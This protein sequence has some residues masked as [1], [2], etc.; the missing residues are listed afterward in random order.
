M[1]S[2][3]LRL[4]TFLALVTVGCARTPSGVPSSWINQQGGVLAGDIGRRP[5]A[6]LTQLTAGHATVRLHLHVLSSSELAAYSWPDGS[7]FVTA[8]LVDR[9]D[10]AE[11]SAAL[12][13][14]VGHLL[15]HPGAQSPAGLSGQPRGAGSRDKEGRAD[16]IGL[17]LLRR[18]HL[19]EAAMI[20][21]LE[22]VAA[23]EP[24]ASPCRRALLRRIEALGRDRHPTDGGG[25]AAAD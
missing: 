15:D 9:L 4:L 2:R 19:P 3:S 24:P 12:A 14:E 17:N 5:Q 13:H 10:D 22:K 11:L 1:P 8:A 25:G 7:V 21:M 16:A 23:A 6:L 18:Q 20:S